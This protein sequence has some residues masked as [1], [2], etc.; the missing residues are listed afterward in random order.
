MF[1]DE[2]ESI[3]EIDPVTGEVTGTRQHISIFPASHYI[4]SKEDMQMAVA[5]IR[6]ELK[7]RL[8]WFRANGKC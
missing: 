3:R 2:I 6:E 4:T 8:D 1:G 5:S 7:E